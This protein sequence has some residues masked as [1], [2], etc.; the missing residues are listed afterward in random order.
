MIAVLV[1]FVF[2]LLLITILAACGANASADKLA[3]LRAMLRESEAAA[4]DLRSKTLKAI[5]ERQEAER[6]K[7]VAEEDAKKSGNRLAAIVVR[8]E[9]AKADR[10]H[11][12]EKY[13]QS[14]LELSRHEAA[15]RALAE[16][17]DSH[18]VAAER[19]KQEKAE[20][21]A[22]YAEA[23]QRLNDIRDAATIRE[24]G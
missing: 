21:A 15:K 8:I 4:E 1:L 24:E 9:G 11:W 18:R 23:L 5:R 22:S 20:L 3:S 7:A 12:H 2:A 10:D 16:A 17:V 19:I 14:L 13:E 6:A